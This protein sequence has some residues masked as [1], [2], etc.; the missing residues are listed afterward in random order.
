[1]GEALREIGRSSADHGPVAARTRVQGFHDRQ[2]K[3]VQ[4]SADIGRLVVGSLPVL[5][6]LGTMLGL[7]NALYNAFSEG[8]FGDEQVQAFVSGLSTALDTTV[9]AMLCAAP[10]F[11]WLTFQTRQESQLIER[12]AEYLRRR[13]SVS[14]LPESDKPTQLMYTELCRLTKQIGQQAKSSFEELLGNSA[15]ALQQALTEAVGQHL[16]Q[17]QRKPAETHHRTD[18]RANNPSTKRL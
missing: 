15:A 13:F 10:L 12:Y 18:S 2:S 5:G 14:D 1:L 4:D 11:A 17:Q 8:L 16:Q 7:S 6:L 9:L 3:A